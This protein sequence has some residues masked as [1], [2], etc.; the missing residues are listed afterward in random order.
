MAL[1][2]KRRHRTFV[3]GVYWMFEKDD[4]ILTL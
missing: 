1:V 3:Q 4:E 2:P